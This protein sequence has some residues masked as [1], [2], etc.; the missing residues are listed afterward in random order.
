MENKVEQKN[1]GK[2]INLNHKNQK[3]MDNLANKKSGQSNNKNGIQ[4]NI[5]VN[6]GNSVKR[7]I[8]EDI[9]VRKQIPREEKRDT[10]GDTKIFKAITREDIEREKKLNSIKKENI[11]EEN[12]S[13]NNV[14]K[15]ESAK[16]HLQN[17]NKPKKKSSNNV[18]NDKISVKS[19]N[20][21]QS[22]ILN[23]SDL[24]N[25]KNNYI[26]QDSKLQR[27]KKVSIQPEI[28]RKSD[29]KSV[30]TKPDY[31]KKIEKQEKKRYNDYKNNSKNNTKDKSKLLLITLLAIIIMLLITVIF[32]TV[33][34]LVNMNSDKII[35][36]VKIDNYEVSNLTRE[37]AINKMEEILNNNQNNY[38]TIR[39]NDYTKQIHLE[40]INGHFNIEETVD[41]AYKVGRN[42]NIV[43]DNYEILK[44][45]ING[46]NIAINFTYDEELLENKINEI[47]IELPDLALDASYIINDN[48]LIIKNSTDG[49]KI[50][51][52][53]F[54]QNV[55]NAFATSEK[56]FDI[57][58]EH[59]EK[60]EVNIDSIHD[61]IYKAPVNAYYTTSPR[62]IY[63]EEDGLDF[64][65]SL[66]EAKKLLNEDKT[67]YEIP[68]KVLK[69][70]ITVNDLDEGAFPNQLST[71][72][73]T[74]GTGDVNRNT[75]IDL[76]ARSINSVVVMPGETFSYNDL[77]GE[78][79]TRT[80]YK[81]S[82]IYMNG[83]LSTGVGGGICQVSTTLY[84]TVL[85]AN[86]EIV[87]RRNHSLGVTYV[88][89][90]QDAMV[91]IG[92]SDFKFKN[93]RDYPIKVVA[94][95]N[96]GS[97]TCQ[98]YGLKQDTEY[99]VR[100]ESRTIEKTDTKY[101]VETYKV[102]YLNGN[103]VSRT[104]LSTDTY[105]TH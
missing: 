22:N 104:W 8:S 74:Y 88:P 33:F 56:L 63:K 10:T 70:Q 17:N 66:D 49:V 57:P 55:I 24:N 103:V 12:I 45:M 51:K 76:A 30:N 42:G 4:K 36:G 61:E 75:N 87:Q 93:N 43:Q 83:E 62:A 58:V 53:Q 1:S 59:A 91:S 99:E 9:P 92:S 3:T 90:G 64:A 13:T 34:G 101:K 79:S 18:G 7:N 5:Q 86:L 47:S 48:K 35:K 82:T 52:E 100:L 38:I 15:F 95:T 72:T 69:A 50:Q 78:C 23:K 60:T 37:E 97:I 67:E 6:K 2:N 11:R 29:V 105:K 94:F 31:N 89:A 39:R 19:N 80:G 20:Y 102:L 44:T 41:E 71:F 68:L 21:V 27:E 16:G 98:I 73:T 54:K 77:I 96:P 14:I 40:D 26:Q 32:S 84:N 25:N 81:E 65:I 28:V 85:R 46:K